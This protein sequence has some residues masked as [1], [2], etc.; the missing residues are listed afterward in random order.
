MRKPLLAQNGS[1]DADDIRKEEEDGQGRKSLCISFC[2]LALSI[3]AL[4]GA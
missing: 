2:T 4:I 3:P 1:R